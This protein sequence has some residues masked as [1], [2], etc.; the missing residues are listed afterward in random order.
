MSE[1]KSI[2][3]GIGRKVGYCLV[4]WVSVL[5]VQFLIF[6]GILFVIENQCNFGKN[7]KFLLDSIVELG[8]FEVI[9]SRMFG[10]LLE[11]FLCGFMLDCLEFFG[12]CDLVDRFCLICKFLRFLSKRICV[13]LRYCGGGGGRWVLLEQN[14]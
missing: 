1:K 13:F 12:F 6:V 3:Y 10:C 14:F 2:V 4:F 9:D 11:L 5:R 7:D 8:W